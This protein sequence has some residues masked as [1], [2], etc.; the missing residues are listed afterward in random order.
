MSDPPAT[1]REERRSPG[2]VIRAMLRSVRYL[3]DRL[4]HGIRRRRALRL[5]R[6]R[7]T[8]LSILVVCH[9]N[10]CRSPYAAG[11]LRRDGALGPDWR[12]DSAGFIG[13]GRRSPGQAR[14]VARRRGVDLDGHIS[15]V[16]SGGIIDASDLIIVMDS[17]QRRAIEDRFEPPG[18]SVLLLGDLDPLPIK[19]RAILDPINQPEEVFAAVYGRIDR[20]IGALGT[21]IGIRRGSPA[22]GDT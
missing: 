9:G 22:T 14:T 19:R 15:K 5:V 1:D 20:C 11:A 10:I 12:V 7:G 16:L 18:A 4:L 13:P 3:P 17:R 8:P 6:S 2:V 21:E